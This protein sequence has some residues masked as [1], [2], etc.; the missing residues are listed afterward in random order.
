MNR[1]LPFLLF[2]LTLMLASC[3]SSPKREPEYLPPRLDCAISD[4]PRQTAPAEPA[5]TEKSVIIWQL[6]AWNWQAYALDVVMQRYES[7]KCVQQLREQQ[8]IR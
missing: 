3:A 2:A 6:Y 1:A 7:A 5:P 4:A 8:V